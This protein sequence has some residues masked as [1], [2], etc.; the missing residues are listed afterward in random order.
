MNDTPTAPEHTDRTEPAGQGTRPVQAPGATP[1]AAAADSAA[2]DSAGGNSAAAGTTATGTTA[3]DTAQQAHAS[4][5]RYAPPRYA[6]PPQYAPPASPQSYASPQPYASPQG[7]PQPDYMQRPA[8]APPPSYPQSYPA[9]SYPVQQN[10]Y[11]VLPEPGPG[12]PYD[13]AA[14][15][16]DLSRPLYGATFA[17]AWARFF[18]NYA[19][20]TG[21]ASRSEFWWVMLTLLGAWFL[22]AVLLGV[23][24]DM[25]RYSSTAYSAYSALSGLY[26]L[27]FFA[28][29]AG[30]FVPI[31]AMTWRR[32][33]D[34]DFPGPF[35][36]LVLF[37]FLGGLALMVMLALPSKVSGRR[38]YRMI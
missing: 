29:L 19:A 17:Q 24:G 10:P 28:I 36:F 5:L 15:P 32:L 25:I 2:V 6:P 13:G 37:P 38:Y 16:A 30:T 14:H 7:Y 27:V 18:K 3:V 35:Y 23:T 33:H 34:A 26:G 21:R 20:F 4:A 22:S 31:L 12:E 11:A 9:P 1:E 8:Y